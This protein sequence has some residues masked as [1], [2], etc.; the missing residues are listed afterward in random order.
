MGV[1]FLFGWLLLSF[2]V[3]LILFPQQIQEGD[4]LG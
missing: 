2:G 1:V 4:M 3:F